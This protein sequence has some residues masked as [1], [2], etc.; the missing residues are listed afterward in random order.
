LTQS[1]LTGHT[2][3]MLTPLSTETSQFKDL[4]HDAQR[5]R[6]VLQT[7]ERNTQLLFSGTGYEYK[8]DHS[9]LAEAFAQWRGTFDKA[10]YLADQ[11]REDFVIYA[12]GLMM[13]ALTTSKPLSVIRSPDTTSNLPATLANRVERWPEGYAYASFCVGLAAAVL[14]EKGAELN[15]GA[16]ADTPAFWDSFRENVDENSNAAIAFF[17]LICGLEPNWDS[18]DVPLLRPAFQRLSIKGA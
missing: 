16:I 6:T 8:V 11:N 15:T 10:K 9:A 14:Q 17:D 4:T 5:F 2:G 7:F 12:A 1:R 3:Y 13:K 18:P